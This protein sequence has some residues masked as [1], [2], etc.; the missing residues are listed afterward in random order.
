MISASLAH[1]QV[2]SVHNV[3]DFHQPKLNNEINALFLLNTYRNG[4][5]YFL[6]E[7]FGVKLILF[8]LKNLEKL[9]GRN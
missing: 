5:L 7:K 3:R 2:L 6:L 4:D 9:W 8:D 1:T